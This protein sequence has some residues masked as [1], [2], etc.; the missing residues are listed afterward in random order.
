MTTAPVEIVTTPVLAV[1]TPPVRVT[2]PVTVRPA[3]AGTVAVMLNTDAAVQVKVPRTVPPPI[4]TGAPADVKVVVPCAVVLMVAVVIVNESVPVTDTVPTHARL[5]RVIEKPVCIAKTV[6]TEAGGPEMVAAE[7]EPEPLCTV[8]AF[9][10]TVPAPPLPSSVLPATVTPLSTLMVPVAVS[11]P[12]KVMPV[13]VP[14][15]K[16]VALGTTAVK[17]MVAAAVQLTVP[18]IE[19]ACTVMPAPAVLVRAE[20]EAVIAMLPMVRVA[21]VL[22]DTDTVPVAPQVSEGK[23]KLVPARAK[24]VVLV[25]AGPLMVP[26]A[27]MVA[28]PLTVHASKVNGPVPVSV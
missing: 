7:T 22:V 19:P 13:A 8:Q 17:E 10:T 21:A 25:A 9:S 16:V 24:V 11:A 20:L 5:A 1:I 4:V 27:V 26:E 2:D 6:V 18:C 28:A 14:T 3:E 12:C 23:F 15:F